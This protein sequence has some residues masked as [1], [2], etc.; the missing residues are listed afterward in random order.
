MSTENNSENGM[1]RAKEREQELKLPK[2]MTLI[3]ADTAEQSLSSGVCSVCGATNDPDALF[4]EHC[5]ARLRELLCPKCGAPLSEDADYCERCHTYVNTD[6]CPFCNGLVDDHDTFCPSCGSPLSGIECPVCHSLGHFGFCGSCGTPLTDSARLEL[7]MAWEDQPYAEK[8]HQ[9]EEELEKLWLTRPV[10]SEQ[11]QADI[12]RVR[13]LCQRVKEL[14]AQEGEN[15]YQV[16]GEPGNGPV[17]MSESELK[18]KILNKQEALQVLLDTMAMPPQEN[19]ALARN[20]AMAR[21]PHI[22]RL[23]WKCNY[24]HALHTS[25]LGCACP[26]MGGKWVITDGRTE[27]QDD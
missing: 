25:P 16:E 26:K 18:Q 14:M 23:A 11:Q 6:H 2:G 20:Y 1:L 3:S 10:E 27:I 9:L 15:T 17:P 21:K 19:S 4:C 22:S 7:Q 12:E 13:M 24:K 5:G 8:V